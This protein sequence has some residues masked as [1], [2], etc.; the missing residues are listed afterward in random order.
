MDSLQL[1]LILITASPKWRGD[2]RGTRTTSLL[3]PFYGLAGKALEVGPK[4]GFM[5]PLPKR[6][7][8]HRPLVPADVVDDPASDSCE[9][10][11]PSP[12]SPWS[13]PPMIISSKIPSCTDQLIRKIIFPPRHWAM[14]VIP[15]SDHKQF[16]YLSSN[17]PRWRYLGV[18]VVHPH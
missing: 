17:K 13:V 7:G 8:F 12:P 3:P 2:N 5:Y 16:F 10:T 14:I 11:K 1:L 4:Q 18:I 9:C 6:R 15:S